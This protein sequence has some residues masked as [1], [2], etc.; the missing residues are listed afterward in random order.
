MIVISRFSLVG[1][2]LYVR[3]LL[4]RCGEE[5]KEKKRKG[6]KMAFMPH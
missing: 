2:I 4:E 6:E 1:C 5:K 3:D